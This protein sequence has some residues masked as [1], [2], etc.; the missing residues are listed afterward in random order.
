MRL[1]GK[2]ALVTGAGS[3]FGAGIARRFAEEGAQVVVNDVNPAGETVAKDIGGRFVQG[4]VTKS[5][6][7]A[8]LVREARA[9]PVLVGIMIPPNY[10]I[11]Y[12]ARFREIYAE[13]AKRERVTLVPFLLDGIAD[14]PD[15]FLADQ[16]HPAAD[17][18][19]RILDNVWPAVEPLLRKRAS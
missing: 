17:A 6:D 11:D 13:I 3:G 14:K 18:Q 4:D 7:W 12:A 16:L 15:L 8:R 9:E 19:P 2:V 5:A 1:K 10:G